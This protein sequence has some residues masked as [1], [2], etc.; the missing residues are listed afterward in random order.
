MEL[1][2]N[3]TSSCAITP[4]PAS[5]FNA[6]V[7]LPSNPCA[8]PMALSRYNRTSPALSAAIGSVARRVPF[9]LSIKTSKLPSVRCRKSRS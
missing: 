9:P 7:T 5:T 8:R 3:A 2:R 1:P 4:P 6:S